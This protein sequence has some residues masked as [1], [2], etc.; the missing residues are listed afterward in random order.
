MGEKKVS[1]QTVSKLVQLISCIAES[2]TPMRLQ[3]ISEHIGVPV[4]TAFRYLNALVEEGL[5]FQD[6]ATNRYAMTWRVCEYGKLVRNHMTIRNLSGSLVSELSVKLSRGV[7]LSIERGMEC[8]YIDCVY[9]P[10]SISGGVPLQ[11]IGLQAPIHAV[12]SGKLFL[13]AYEE[14]DIDLLVNQK[15]LEQ[16]TE[17][18][19][20]TKDDLMEE[21]R[22]TKN[23]QYALDDQECEPGLRCVAVPIYDYSGEIAAALSCFGKVEN[24]SFEQI[25]SDILPELRSVAKEISFRMGSY[26]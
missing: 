16:L 22:R 4:A 26:E 7:S 11:R 6:G 8:V 13:T 23:N 9:D 10:T 12:S 5:V 2:R 20:T 14:S 3:D 19:I 25:H 1:N 17:K 15:G 21:L 24:M 18:T